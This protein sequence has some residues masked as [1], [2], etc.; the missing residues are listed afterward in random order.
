MPRS[1][2]HRLFAR[3]L[4]AGLA[5]ATMIA[6]PVLAAPRCAAPADQSMFE[7][8]AL[9]S[10]LLVVAIACKRNE[11]YNAFVQRYR[12][13][14]L[15]LDKN[16][17]AHFKKAHGGRWQKVADDFTTDMANVR[18]TMASRMG[19]DHC[20]RNGL[21]FNEVMALPAV[22][23]L[24]AYA[25]GKDLLPASITTCHAAATPT[26]PAR[27]TRASTAPARPAAP[28]R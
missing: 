1:P 27:A 3:R 25:A 15:D 5:V 8:F 14:L 7:L 21:I 2:L 10:E 18:S 6:Q 22:S 26:T 28:R 4:L 17:N 20:P 23:D 16:L 9:K 19:G 11:S 12:P 13:A 24:P